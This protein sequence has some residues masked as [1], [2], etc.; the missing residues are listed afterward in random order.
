MPPMIVCGWCGQPT[1]AD[2]CANCQ[3]DP[4]LPWTQRAQQPPPVDPRDRERRLLAEARASLG[5][6]ATVEQLAE[7]LDISPR[8]VRRWRE[9][10]A[11]GPRIAPDPA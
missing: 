5:R 2:R 4:V 3:R 11:P 10:S 1:K 8:T 6:D 7:H 9:M